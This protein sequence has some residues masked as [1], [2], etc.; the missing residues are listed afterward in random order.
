M[1]NLLSLFSGGSGLAIYAVAATLLF[2]GG[3]YVGYQ[4]ESGQRAK[5]K[6]AMAEEATAKLKAAT[7][8]SNRLS[9]ALEK[10]RAKRD[11]KFGELS[12]KLD[13][14]TKRPVYAT[15]CI[16]DDGLRVIN[17][18][19]VG[20]PATS[21]KPDKSVPAPAPAFWRG[22]FGSGAEAGGNGKA[23]Q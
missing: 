20:A 9:V 4:Y 12:S 2:G 23:I 11:E 5:E 22:W 13:D 8:K 15:R 10:E 14:L 6:V 3:A 7:D 16:D 19:L 18:A 21:G 1:M 17:D